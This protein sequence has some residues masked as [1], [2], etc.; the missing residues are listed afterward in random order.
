MHL[1][2]SDIRIRVTNYCR[3]TIQPETRV[4]AMIYL[5]FSIWKSEKE[6]IE[7]VHWNNNQVYPVK[8]SINSLT[9]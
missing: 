5:T 3:N 1:I 7:L 8:Q 9:C 2:L 4:G 6:T